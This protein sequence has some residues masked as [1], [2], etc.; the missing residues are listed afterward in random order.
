MTIDPHIVFAS[1]AFVFGSYIASFLNVC[2]WRIPRGESVVWPG[3]HCPKCNAPIRWYHNIPVISWL[4]LRG[5][6]ASC[7]QPISVRYILLELLGG[8]VSL[9]V[10]LL[11]AEPFFIGARP[12]M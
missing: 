2:I 11:W 3:S 5:R 8:V 9:L 12:P 10:W 4:V 6:C 7:K 1:L